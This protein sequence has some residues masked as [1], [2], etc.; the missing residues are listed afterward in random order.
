MKVICFK[1]YSGNGKTGGHLVFEHICEAMKEIFVVEVKEFPIYDEP[2]LRKKAQY[3]MDMRRC[4]RNAIKNGDEIYGLDKAGTIDY[5]IPIIYKTWFSGLLETFKEF[6]TLNY[7]SAFSNRRKACIFGSYYIKR[8][9]EEKNCK[10][11]V[12]YPPLLE[13]IEFTDSEK[14]NIILT[15]SRISRGNRSEW[16]TKSYPP[17]KGWRNQKE[18]DKYN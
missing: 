4:V 7:L 15:I 8:S 18:W 10:G 9:Y 6:L 5:V 16:E 17:G 1:Q 13:K 3:I 14:E 12:I 11:P 2:S